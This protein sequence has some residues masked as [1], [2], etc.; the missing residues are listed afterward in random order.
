MLRR[1]FLLSSAAA[2]AA[3]A[4]GAPLRIGHRQANMTKQA[5]PEVFD[6]ARRIPGLSGVELQVQY[7]GTTLWDA[8]TRAEYKRA[9][10]R[11]GLVIPSLAGLWGKGASMVDTGP[12]EESIRKSVQAAEALGARV[13]LAAGFG[14]KCPK[15]DD[16]SSYGPVVA[17]LQKVAPAAADA[18]V[19]VGL[20]TSLSPADDKKLV[21]LVNRPSIRTYYDAFNCEHYGHK[22]Q[23]LPGYEVLGKSRIAQVHLKNDNHL[24]EEPGP[25]DWTAALQAL[26]R[27]GYSGWLVFETAHTGPEQCVEATKKNIEFIRKRLA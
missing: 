4:A 3:K 5:G 8:A 7:Q 23:A 26:K 12:G 11:T 18:G 13:I 15:M 14:A 27:I 9:A 22:G 2:L 20:E 6:L 25:V 19:V 17:M 24:L 1:N 16:E 21:D 10:E